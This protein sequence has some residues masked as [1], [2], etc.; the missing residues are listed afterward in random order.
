MKVDF[1]CSY[2]TLL[3]SATPSAAPSK[4]VTLS[5]GHDAQH[6][7]LEFMSTLEEVNPCL[8]NHPAACRISGGQFEFEILALQKKPPLPGYIFH[9]FTSRPVRNLLRNGSLVTAKVAAESSITASAS[10][11]SS[12]GK[13]VRSFVSHKMAR[14]RKTRGHSNHLPG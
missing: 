11:D 5:L 9:C 7:Q 3:K 2:Q 8:L 6:G 13:V 10:G 14:L 1:G 4:R 12:F